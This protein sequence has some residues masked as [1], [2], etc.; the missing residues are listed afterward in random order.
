MRRV[1][2]AYSQSLSILPSE[3]AQRGGLFTI[4]SVVFLGRSAMKRPM[5]RQKR[6]REHIFLFEEILSPGLFAKM[7]FEAI[8]GIEGGSHGADI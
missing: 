4:I 3:Q 8:S 5:R 1:V 7:L 2:V 6:H